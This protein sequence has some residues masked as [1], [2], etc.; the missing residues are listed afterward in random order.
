MHQLLYHHSL[1]WEIGR[2]MAEDLRHTGRII[3]FKSQQI[4]SW[5]GGWQPSCRKLRSCWVSWSRYGAELTVVHSTGS[6]LEVAS[7]C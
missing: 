2:A 4:S 1:D 7:S 3:A 5:H 6:M